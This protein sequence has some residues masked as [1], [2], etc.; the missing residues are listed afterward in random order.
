M[1]STLTP[2]RPRL[3]AA[4][5]AALA[6]AI[7]ASPRALAAREPVPPRLPV[8]G[9]VA[10]LGA[11]GRADDPQAVRELQWG[12]RLLA[13]FPYPIDGRYDPHTREAVRRFQQAHGLPP[14]GVADASTLRALAQRFEQQARSLI[15]SQRRA[16]LAA[17]QPPGLPLHPD[18]RRGGYWIVVDTSRLVLTLYRDGQVEARWP[19]AVGRPL[20]MTPVGE[21]RIV[22]KGYAGGVFGSR[23]MGLDIPFGSYGIHGTDRPWSIGTQASAGCIRMFNADVEAL[24][25]RVSEGTPVTIVGSLPEVSWDAPLRPG[26]VDFPVPLLQWAL[27]RHGFDPGRADARLG[28]ATLQAIQEAQRVLGLPRV[29]A[30]T[31]DLYRAL[32]LK[33]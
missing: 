2:R 24:F 9:E 15:D 25:D 30:A 19:V 18:A 27:R 29:E 8:C 10:S 1:P 31:P 6:A 7:V 12:L 17:P 33:R 11:P 28:P 13:L 4:A 32:G 26:T 14:T 23:W 21:W 3:A 16:A 22:D 5:A 20:S